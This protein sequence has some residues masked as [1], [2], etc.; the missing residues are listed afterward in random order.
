VQHNGIRG[1]VNT[2]LCPK[3]VHNFRFQFSNSKYL[4][5]I[6]DRVSY[7]FIL[8]TSNSLEECYLLETGCTWLPDVNEIKKQETIDSYIYKSKAHVTLRLSS[9]TLHTPMYVF[10]NPNILEQKWFLTKFNLNVKIKL[11]MCLMNYA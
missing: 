1:K 3:W 6:N 2:E 11:L 7:S 10:V 8:S 5:L 9:K 4:G